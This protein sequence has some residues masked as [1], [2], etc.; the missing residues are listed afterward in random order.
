MVRLKIWYT[1]RA[2]TQGERLE[3]VALLDLG[4]TLLHAHLRR[5]ERAPPLALPPLPAPPRAAAPARPPSLPLRR[6][7]LASAESA[8]RAAPLERVVQV[9][10]MLKGGGLDDAAG[11]A[12]GGCP[13][14]Q[15]RTLGVLRRP[16]E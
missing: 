16:T 10:W 14:A 5:F 3:R 11:K 4:T 13:G 1:T 6:R 9:A 7:G 15:S 12:V 2:H 8:R